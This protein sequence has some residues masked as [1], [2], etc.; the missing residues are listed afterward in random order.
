MEKE[1]RPMSL[2][3]NMSSEELHALLG[4]RTS[5]PPQPSDSDAAATLPFETSASGESVAHLKESVR[6]LSARVELL[7]S[8]LSLLRSQLAS[9]VQELAQLHQL[10]EQG[11]HGAVHPAV[12]LAQAYLAQPGVLQVEVPQTAI[13]QAPQVILSPAG[14]VQQTMP[15]PRLKQAA[16][17]NVSPG[18]AALRQ[19]PTAS[20][21]QP[22]V[23]DSSDSALEPRSAKHRRK[24]G[25]LT[26]WFRKK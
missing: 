3:R 11:Y 19:R 14:R 20:P 5:E 26:R 7:E 24:K 9:H 25:L 13:L 16:P 4:S 12:A 10:H 2:S 6:V 22:A 18:D 23:P 1:V 17:E 15:D 21:P 8:E